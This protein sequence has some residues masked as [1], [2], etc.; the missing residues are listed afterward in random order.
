[1]QCI[2]ESIYRYSVARVELL[3]C[4]PDIRDVAGELRFAGKLVVNLR[5]QQDGTGLAVH[6]KDFG[7]AG[8]VQ[9]IKCFSG[10][11]PEV[12]Q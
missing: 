3:N 6:G 1:M 9:P 2:E 5:R 8:L 7:I 10:F 11:L 4:P 12:S